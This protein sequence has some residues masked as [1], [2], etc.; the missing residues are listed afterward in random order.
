[1]LKLI[2]L[3]TYR[4][5]HN[6]IF[7]MTYLILIPIVMAIA[8]YFTNTISYSMQ[9]AI[10]GNI[11]VVTND[12]IEYIYLDTIPKDSQMVLNQ[13]DAICLQENQAIKVIST[14][15]EDFNQALLKLVTGQ[16]DALPSS[17]EQR[18]TASNILGFLM[19]I[20]SL[21]GVQIYQYYF[22]ERKGINKRILS[23]TIH[24]YQYMLSHFLVSFCFMFV[25]A[26]IMIG[27]AICLIGIPLS[28][29]LWQFFLVLL[30]LCFFAT[31][32]G[33]WIN[34]ACKSIEESMI[35]GNMFAIVGA[36]VSGGFV[37]V[38]NNEI[39]NHIVQFFPQ[40]QIMSLLLALENN[41]SLP[42]I[43]IFYILLLSFVFI[44]FA[45]R[46]EK[47]KLPSR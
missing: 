41:H 34:A 35:F 31:A 44:V 9:I 19:M 39:F 43:G 4:I 1:M 29:A 47:R 3:I 18:G 38:T 22:E 14:K 2:Q 45:I 21:L 11:D 8:I 26:L 10:V 17:G 28:I 25:P 42:I 33:L 15:G 23:T 32:F 5:T 12:T 6:K 36:I 27:G 7:L 24:Y 20:I 30:L 13:Y 40:K 46:L 37:Q 16:I